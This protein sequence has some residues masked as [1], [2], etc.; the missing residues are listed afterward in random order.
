M[1]NQSQRQQQNLQ[2]RNPLS[3]RKS[4]AKSNGFLIVASVSSGYY[5]SAINLAGS[6]LD[7]YPEAKIAL[8]TEKELFKEEHRHLFDYVES[9]SPHHIRAKLWALPRSPYATTVYIDADCE[10]RDEEISEAFSLLD[11][12]ELDIATTAVRDYS[13]AFVYFD[14]NGEQTKLAH[15]CGVF[16]YNDKPQT[17]EFMQSWWEEYLEQVSGEWNYPHDRRLKPWDQYTFWRLLRDTRYST[18]VKVG[19]IEGEDARWNFVNNYKLEEVTKDPII[20]HYTLAK[21]FIDAGRLN[22]K[23]TTTPDT[24]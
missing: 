13:G 15:H 6:I 17:L 2:P 3:R 14:D 11:S 12:Q 1:L 7:F 21:D 5:D 4:P 23:Q 10:V 20:F 9:N 16:V 24:E 19:F 18:S 8:F 22:K